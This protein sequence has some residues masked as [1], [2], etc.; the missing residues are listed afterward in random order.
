MPNSL[1]LPRPSG[2]RDSSTSEV[3]SVQ[4]EWKWLS[5]ELSEP[6]WHTMTQRVSEIVDALP[7][8]DNLVP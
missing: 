3:T 2:S 8:D 1:R 6:K 5:Q 7:K 4:M